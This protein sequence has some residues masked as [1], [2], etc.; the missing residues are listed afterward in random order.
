HPAGAVDR[1]AARLGRAQW[2][3]PLAT[4]SAHELVRLAADRRHLE[5]LAPARVLER[6][7][8]VVRRADGSVVRQ[9]A[10]V[11]AGDR[12]DVQLCAGRLGVSVEA[13]R[14]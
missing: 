2:H 7:Y 1:A 14:Q 12:L 13:V 9:A 6:G 8:A 3:R 10:A 4:R 11:A 5:A